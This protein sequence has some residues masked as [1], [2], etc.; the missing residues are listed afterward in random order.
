MTEKRLKTSGF[1]LHASPCSFPFVKVGGHG[2]VP[3]KPS[4]PWIKWTQGIKWLGVF[5]SAG[6]EVYV[7]AEEIVVDKYQQSGQLNIS[8]MGFPYPKKKTQWPNKKG[9]LFEINCRLGCALGHVQQNCC[10]RHD[11]VGNLSWFV[12]VRLSRK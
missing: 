11:R 3:E 9:R 10:G 8:G 12:F 2:N 7:R 6:S 4:A 1:T 5:S